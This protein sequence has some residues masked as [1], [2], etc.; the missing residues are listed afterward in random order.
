MGDAEN[1]PCRRKTYS[2]GQLFTVDNSRLKFNV[3]GRTD[4]GMDYGLVIVLD[5][6]TDKD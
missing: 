4:R 1:S 5:G 3:D 2:R 6:N